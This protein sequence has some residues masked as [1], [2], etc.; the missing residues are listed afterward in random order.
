MLPFIEDLKDG[1][2]VRKF[3]SNLNEDELKWHW[4]QED[5]IVICEH[6]TDWLLQLDNELPF[7]I[8]KNQA[9]FINEG[10][11]HRLIKGNGDL[12]IKIKKIKNKNL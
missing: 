2:Y 7:K 11:Y 6:E 9:I 8:K 4:D 3:S 5:R 1:Y 10:Q 12:T